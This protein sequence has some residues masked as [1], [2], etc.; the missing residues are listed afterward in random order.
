MNYQAGF[1]AFADNRN[2]D[3]SQSYGYSHIG[4][5][6][7]SYLEGSVKPLEVLMV[8]EKPSIART[9]ADC[10]T[11]GKYL[12]RRGMLELSKASPSSARYL[13]T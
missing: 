11:G 3:H 13:S 10:L 9:I 12:T 6:G 4:A 1:K 2:L 7:Q 8:A 5:R